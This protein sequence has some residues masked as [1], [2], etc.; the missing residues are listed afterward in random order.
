MSNILFISPH[1][2]DYHERLIQELKRQNYNVFWYADRPSETFFSKVFIRLNKKILKNKID[3]YVDFIIAEQSNANI[4]VV[5]IIL[6]QSFSKYHI[7]SMR[8]KFSNAKFIY[9]AWDSIKNFS[10]IEEIYSLFDYS[11]SFD[12]HDCEKTGMKFLPLFYSNEYVSVEE[13]KYD[14]SIIMTIKKGKLF[15]L[16]R[17]LSKLPNN[18]NGY[19]YLY[20]QSKLVFLYYKLFLKEFR[21]A[22]MSDFMYKP[23]ASSEVKEIMS[24]SKVV[25]DCQMFNQNGLTIRTFETIRMG[26][27]LITT[28]NNV[29]EYDFYAP[30]NI[31]IIGQEKIGNSFFDT[32]FDIK[33]S[34]SDKYSIESFVKN[35]LNN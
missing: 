27:K 9:Y 8:K 10:S 35:I 33:Y 5:L 11:F 25:I 32:K 4:D 22:K 2:F 26:C 18:L 7:E 24:K 6:G 1:F 3:K 34:L 13:K 16:N 20:L 12:K 30:Q 14:Y 28:N 17:V 23:L 21:G 15:N 31:H 29:A 19:H